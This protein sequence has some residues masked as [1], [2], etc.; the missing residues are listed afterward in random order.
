MNTDEIILIRLNKI[1]MQHGV[2]LTITHKMFYLKLVKYAIENGQCL[3]DMYIIEKTEKE[4]SKILEISSRMVTQSLQ[5]LIKC[6]VIDRIKD[7]N[8]FPRK[9]SKTIIYKEIIEKGVE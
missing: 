4:L 2:K 3:D 6:G 5:V 7:E 9:A 1:A 8:N